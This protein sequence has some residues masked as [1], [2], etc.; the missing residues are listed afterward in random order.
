VKPFYH[1]AIV[2]GNSQLL[3]GEAAATVTF[4][5]RYIEVFTEP[6]DVTSLIIHPI[7]DAHLIPSHLDHEC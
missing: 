5:N 1:F 3:A 6:Y 7:T 4:S 2:H